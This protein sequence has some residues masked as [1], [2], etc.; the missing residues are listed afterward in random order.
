MNN[1]NAAIAKVKELVTSRDLQGR[2]ICD[3]ELGNAFL[4][5]LMES[6][7]SAVEP[8]FAFL[9]GSTRQ[10]VHAMLKEFAKRDYYDDRHAYMNDGRTLEERRQHYRSM[11]SH[12]HTVGEKLL[13]LLRSQANHLLELRKKT[14]LYQRNLLTDIEL[15]GFFFHTLVSRPEAEVSA[16]CEI[17]PA[18]A[19]DILRRELA[20]IRQ[21]E[22]TYI[23]YLIGD[24]RTTE[25]KIADAVHSS[26]KVKQVC[27]EIDLWFANR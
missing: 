22:Y 25:Q 7:L 19:E 20:R 11:Q 21:A 1:A 23:P 5:V 18:A 24:E 26:P 27:E 17:L 2:G 6:E 10:V 4:N 13:D 8:C 12:Y 14:V 15:T 16:A 9:G 3:D